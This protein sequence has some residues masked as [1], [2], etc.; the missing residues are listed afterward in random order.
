MAKLKKFGN[1][2][3]VPAGAKVIDAKGK[4]VYPVSF[5]Q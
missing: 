3:S 1:D 2:I 5:Y 4:Q